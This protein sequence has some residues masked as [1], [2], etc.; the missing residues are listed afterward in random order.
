MTETR[1]AADVDG[2]VMSHNQHDA[3]NVIAFPI[4]ARIAAITR[5]HAQEV[6][7]V[8]RLQRQGKPARMNKRIVA[9]YWREVR[10]LRLPL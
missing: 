9:E 10:G 7:R 5:A 4:P 3:S 1:G 8:D 6:E 2:E